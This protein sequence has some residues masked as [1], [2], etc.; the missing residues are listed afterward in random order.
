[1]KTARRLLLVDDDRLVLATLGEG[2]RHSGYDVVMASSGEQALALADMAPPDLAILDVRMPGMSGIETAQH[3][4]ERCR[5]PYLFL[6]ACSDRDIVR[7]AVAQGALAYVVKPV[8]VAQ[9]VPAIETSLGQAREMGALRER[10]AGLAT[11]LNQ[12]RETSAAIGIVMERFRLSRNQ[13]FELLRARAR[14]Q[15]RKLEELSRELVGAAEKL[16]F[17]AEDVERLRGSRSAE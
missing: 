16:S 2:L 7:D 12:G 3:L 17:P 9:L 10:E 6:S 13:A 11:A 14:S 5:T 1:M 8:D 15:R 4:R